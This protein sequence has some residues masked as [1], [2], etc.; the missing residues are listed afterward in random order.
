ME[1]NDIA[2]M[3]FTLE[4]VKDVGRMLESNQ[5]PANTQKSKFLILAPPESR[6]ELLKEAEANPIK[7]WGKKI[8]NSRAKKNQGIE[9]MKTEHLPA[10][11]Q[12]KT[13]E[14]T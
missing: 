2:K 10:F 12:L 6:T 13:Q 14:F 7:I 3:N 1:S 11:M 9:Y 8:E 4:D 5:L